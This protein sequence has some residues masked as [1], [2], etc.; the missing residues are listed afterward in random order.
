MPAHVDQAASAPQGSKRK[1]ASVS[2]ASV[3]LYRNVAIW[4]ASVETIASALQEI[5][6]AEEKQNFTCTAY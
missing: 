2:T 1:A 5:A 4:T 6:N 3:A